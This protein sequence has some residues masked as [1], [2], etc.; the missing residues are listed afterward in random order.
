MMGTTLVAVKYNGGVLLASDT[1]VSRGIVMNDRSSKKV[2]E[3]SPSPKKF[4]SVKVLRC[5]AAA[6]SQYVS[7][8]VY[9]YLNFF[10]MDLADN[11]KLDILTVV[12]LYKQIL[13]SNKVLHCAFIIT[14]GEEI[15]SVMRGGAYFKHNLISTNGSGS[16]YI[17]GY[18]RDK[19]TPNMSFYQ[20]R[21]ILL[22]AVALAIKV[23]AS[24]GG[25]IRLTNVNNKGESSEEVILNKEI[26][27]LI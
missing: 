8:I 5:G 10:C 17:N 14:N 12:N 9:N 18:L 24:S 21:E 2:M 22:K 1:L 7:R 13:Y 19:L 4:G 3:L 15:Y 6:H 11:Q 27:N 16:T 25:N 26:K 23:D 20:T